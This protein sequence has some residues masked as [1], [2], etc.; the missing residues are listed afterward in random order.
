MDPETASL[1]GQRYQ[2]SASNTYV[3]MKI[4][5]DFLAIYVQVSST[6]HCEVC[7]VH[8]YFLIIIIITFQY[9]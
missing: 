4:K 5:N 8:C 6:N 2:L 1:L 9:Y 7:T 3:A